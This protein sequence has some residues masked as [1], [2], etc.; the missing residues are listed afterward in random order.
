MKVNTTK[1]TM[2]A[3]K[4]AF[5]YSLSQNSPL[6]AELLS[7]CGIDFILL[8]R[9]HGSWGEESTIAAF[10]GAGGLGDLITQGLSLNQPS[11]I[12]LGAIPTALLALVVDYGLSQ[13]EMLL[14]PLNL[15]SK[16]QR[17]S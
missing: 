3:G 6:N 12:L 7:N 14:T 5:G 15:L 13:L 1:E 9:Q 10:I 16:T 2:Q 11:L 8:D 4:P 17:R